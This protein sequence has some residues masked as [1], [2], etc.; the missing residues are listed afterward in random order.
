M[1]LV[2]KV[3]VPAVPGRILHILNHDIKRKGN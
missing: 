3:T 1:Y 2:F